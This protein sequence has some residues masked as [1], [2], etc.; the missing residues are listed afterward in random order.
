MHFI[1]ADNYLSSFSI[2]I[3]FYGSCFE[4]A[5]LYSKPGKKKKTRQI[6]RR[7]PYSCCLGTCF[8]FF[9]FNNKIFYGGCPE[10][11]ILIHWSLYLTLQPQP[12]TLSFKPEAREYDFT[13]GVHV[14]QHF[15]RR[16]TVLIISCFK[17]LTLIYP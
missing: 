17:A 13:R 2:I 12:D 4:A 5:F 8:F 1:H 15:E 6:L 3:L 14:A 9:F 16:Q 7:A 10:P 11:A